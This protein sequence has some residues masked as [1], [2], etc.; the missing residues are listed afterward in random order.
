VGGGG[1]VLGLLTTSKERAEVACA[2]RAEIRRPWSLVKKRAGTFGSA[3]GNLAREKRRVVR[4][5]EEEKVSKKECQ[6]GRST[7]VRRGNQ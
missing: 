5:A 4:R 3:K 6:Q 7:Q 1:G 2:P